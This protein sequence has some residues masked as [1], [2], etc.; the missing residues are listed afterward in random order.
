[1]ES[2]NLLNETS[3]S[4][5]QNENK[6]PQTSSKVSEILDIENMKKQFLKDFSFF[7]IIELKYFDEL[8]I[9]SMYLLKNS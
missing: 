6:I 4:Q 5:K 1:M 2:K 7:S 8:M 9:K 3:L